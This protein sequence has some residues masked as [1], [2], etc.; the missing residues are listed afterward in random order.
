MRLRMMSSITIGDW[1]AGRSASQA[2][3][4]G[5]DHP[6]RR[7]AQPLE[8]LEVDLEFLLAR[9]D[10]RKLVMAVD[11]GAAVSRDMLDHADHA[12]RGKPVEHRAAERGDLHR[13]RS[14]RAVADDVGR[15][16]LADV[17]HRQAIDV[18]PDSLSISASARAF[19]RAA[20]IADEGAGW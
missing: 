10:D 12:R 11:Q 4:A 2:C 8:R 16:R 19:T 6:H 9:I 20:S 14:Q 7:V 3:K 5:G 13:L 15:A 1:I 17:E 18:D